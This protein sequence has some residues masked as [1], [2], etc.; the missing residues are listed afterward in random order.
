VS[1]TTTIRRPDLQPPHRGVTAGDVGM[2]VVFVLIAV[3][4]AALG[5]IVS[6]SE[7]DG[8]YAS[9]SHVT[10]TPPNWAFGAVWSVLYLLIAV[11]GWLLWL[12]RARG[13]LVLYVA[14]LVV[15]AIWTPVFFGAYPVIGE[16]ALWLGVAIIV[17]LDLLVAAT[18]TTAWSVSRWAA[19][20]LLP[21][22]AW[23]LYASTLNWGDAV[24]MTLS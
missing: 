8:W 16:P 7:V 12:R 20:L 15:N 22:L 14:Q 4:V 23:I 11:S 1:Y 3:A 6:V 21:Y 18:I 10:W 9:A 2:L 19:V 17:L 5:S 24:L 13:P